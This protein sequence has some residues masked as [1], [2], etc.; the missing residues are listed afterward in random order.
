MQVHRHGFW[1]AMRRM[2]LSGWEGGQGGER[3]RQRPAAQQQPQQQ[4]QP[5]RQR[6]GD[7][8]ISTD[9]SISAS[10]ACQKVYMFCSCHHFY[11]LFL[12]TVCISAGQTQQR[13]R[14]ERF[15]EVARIV[16]SLPLE[17]FATREDMQTCSLHMLRVD[18]FGHSPCSWSEVEHLVTSW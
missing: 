8:N 16:Q 1:P 18:L 5:P 17:N 14:Q 13:P 2:F 3:Q 6:Q 4:Q 15:E 10:N 7:S 12:V 11:A 9:S